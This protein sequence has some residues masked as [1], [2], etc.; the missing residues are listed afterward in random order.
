M[1]NICLRILSAV[2]LKLL[3]MNVKEESAS[4]QV[5][6]KGATSTREGETRRGTSNTAGGQQVSGRSGDNPSLDKYRFVSA[7]QKL[8]LCF[9]YW[10]SVQVLKGKDSKMGK[11]N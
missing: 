10:V 9:L 3:Q 7:I 4:E 8:I 1:A 5:K 6:G 2:F 11:Q